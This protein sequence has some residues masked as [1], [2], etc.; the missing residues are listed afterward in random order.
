MKNILLLPLFLL[1]TLTTYA[2]KTLDKGVI[3]MELTEASSEN[4]Q[5][6]AVFEMMKGSETNYV[7]NEEKALVTQTFM[8]GMVSITS[9]NNFKTDETTML[10]D[11]MGQKMMVETNAKE[12]ESA[13]ELQDQNKAMENMKITYDEADTKSILGYTCHKAN[14]DVGNG[15]KVSL[16][17]T[18][19]IKASNTLIKGLEG[20]ELN[21]FPLEMTMNTPDFKMVYTTT[22][23]L[24]EMDPAV[25]KVNTEGYKKMTF[26]EFQQTM[27]GMGGMGF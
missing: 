23:I 6:S 20:M 12:L 14:V 16:Y 18:E 17:V 9:L 27:G 5:M 10:F 24:T 7:F 26:Q 21:G 13:K 2:Q 15:M 8:G 22:E 19:D 3:K 25:L 1:L 11:M 4:E